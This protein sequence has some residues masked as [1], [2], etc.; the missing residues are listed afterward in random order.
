MSSWIDWQP[1]RRTD[2]S[3]AKAAKRAREAKRMNEPENKCPAMLAQS[4]CCFLHGE[5]SRDKG[6][7]SAF[8]QIFCGLDALPAIHRIMSEGVL[9]SRPLNNAPQLKRPL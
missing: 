8:S 7:P 5:N 2:N 1:P 6:A 4:G 9:S 3:G